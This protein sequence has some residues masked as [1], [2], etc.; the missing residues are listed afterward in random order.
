M[1]L[2][3]EDNKDPDECQS[4]ISTIDIS[5]FILLFCPQKIREK[6]CLLNALNAIMRILNTNGVASNAEL[7]WI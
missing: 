1:M 4:V 3:Y 7:S 5:L 2:L 6:A